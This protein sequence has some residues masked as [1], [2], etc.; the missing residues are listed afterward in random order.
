MK[1]IWNRQRID[2]V[3][4]VREVQILSNTCLKTC[5]RMNLSVRFIWLVKRSLVLILTLA[6]VHIPLQS[7]FIE[8]NLRSAFC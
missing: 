8:N 2:C 4:H 1:C 5:D 3:V 6:T 7:Q